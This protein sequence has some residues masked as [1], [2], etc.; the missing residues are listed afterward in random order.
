MVSCPYCQFANQDSEDVCQRCGE[1]LFSLPSVTLPAPL[2]APMIEP[3]DAPLKP[4]PDSKPLSAQPALSTPF[5]KKSAVGVATTRRPSDA[6]PAPATLRELS[7]PDSRP[8]DRTP[9]GGTSPAHPGL[10]GYP[11][12]DSALDNP[13]TVPAT[14]QADQAPPPVPTVPA[15]RPKLVVLRGQRIDTE[16]PVYEGR[17]TI[18]R[19][20]DRPVDIDLMN[21]EA[22]EQIWCSRQHAVVVFEGGVL[23]VEDLNSLNGTWVNGVRVHPGQ[24]RQ[25]KPGDVI[26]IGTVQ[27][28]FVL[29]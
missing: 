4:P 7:L 29:E 16:Y 23:A 14:D 22:I 24:R 9:S 20:A 3:I 5:A 18:G 21:Q 17:N 2:P 15:L 13:Q 10:P 26:Q 12:N 25:L 19:F 6:T 1:E 11:M 28:K 27:L 8:P